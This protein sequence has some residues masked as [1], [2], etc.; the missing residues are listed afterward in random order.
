[1]FFIYTK[2]A[3]LDSG[4]GVRVTSSN[5][6]YLELNTNFGLKF[7][8]KNSDELLFQR[9][10][11]LRMSINT[12]VMLPLSELVLIASGLP[13]LNRIYHKRFEHRK[14]QKEKLQV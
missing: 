5:N 9:F 3:P 13:C 8:S 4:K 10:L 11:Y 6:I 14:L 12:E 2:I 7:P 1:M